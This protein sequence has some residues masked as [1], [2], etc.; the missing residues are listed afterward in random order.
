MLED[1]DDWLEDEECLD[2]RM[3]WWYWERLNLI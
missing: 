1:L 3:T 2:Y